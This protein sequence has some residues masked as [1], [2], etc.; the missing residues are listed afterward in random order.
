M[1]RTARYGVII[2]VMAALV[3]CS[4]AEVGG[5]SSS[6]LG[7]QADTTGDASSTDG[8]LNDPS[9]ANDVGSEPDAPPGDTWANYAEG[10]LTTYC[11]SCHSPSGMASADFNQY[12]VV[13]DEQSTIRCGTSDVQLDDCPVREPYGPRFPVGSGPFPEDEDRAR[14]VAWIDAG[15]PL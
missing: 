8:A 14:F 2:L 3:G 7:T 13:F 12:E 1:E 10:F 4:D 6:D 9:T 5:G 15:L 11:T